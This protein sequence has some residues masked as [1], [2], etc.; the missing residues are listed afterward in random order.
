V[1]TGSPA[2]APGYVFVS[3]KKEPGGR[4]PSQDAPLILDGSGEPVW[5]HPLSDSR[6]D[7]FNFKVQKYK[8]EKVL[9]WWVGHHSGYGHGEY[10]LADRTYKEI[11]RVRAGNG[12]KGDHHEFLITSADTALLTVYGEEVMDLSF[13]GGPVDG[14]VLDGVVQEVDI[15][16]GEVL[17]EWHSLDHVGLEESYYRP[18]PDL[19]WAFDYFHINSVDANPD[20]Y[21]TI[22]ARRT[23]A[24]YK[25]DR[26]NGEVIWRLGGKNSDFEMGPGTSIHGQ[27]DARSHPDNIITIFDNGRVTRDEQSR[28]I[29]VEVDEDAM[30]ATLVGEYVRPERTL[31]DTQGNVQILPGGHVFVGWGSEPYFSEFSRDGELLFDASFPPEV[32]SYRAF[33][34]PWKGEPQTR[35]AVV[36][37]TGEGDEVHIFISWNG[38]TEV[39]T[40]QVLAGPGPDKLRSVGSFP[41][42]GFETVA[43]LRAEGPHF[44][45]MAEDDAGQELATS[46]IVKPQDR[47]PVPPNQKRGQ[48]S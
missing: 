28:G 32:E 25:V 24:I 11:I 36:V 7:A 9:T 12:Y 26:E 41:R 31:S 40:W 22:S 4:A 17:F 39:A 5:F 35:P 20:G 10:V 6:E 18:P 16:T 13:V 30:R 19:D 2:A 47:A 33:R 44:A 38:A 45:V 3:P 46:R 27:H 1:F 8:G 15:E 43:T 34:F 37:E 23:C 29:V 21:L 42:A 48:E 14:R